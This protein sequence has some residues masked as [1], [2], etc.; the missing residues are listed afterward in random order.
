MHA[1]PQLLLT[2]HDDRPVMKPLFITRFSLSSKSAIGVQTRRFM[3]PFPDA[4]HLYW[5]QRDLR[6]I[7]QRSRSI[8]KLLVSRLSMLRR[9]GVLTR[10][11]RL[12]RMTHWSGSDPSSRIQ[13]RLTASAKDTSV[14]YLAPIG[15][16]DASRMRRIVELI[17]RPF[18]VHLW[19]SLDV[20]PALNADL[21]WLLAHADKVYGLTG[22]LMAASGRDDAEPLLFSRARADVRATPPR[23]GQPL[24]IATMGDLVSYQD[25]LAVL[26]DACARLQARGHAVELLYIGPNGA[27]RRLSKPLREPLVRT[28]FLSSDQRRDEV[29]ASCH[30]GFMPGPLAAPEDDLRSRFSVPSRVLDFMAVGLPVVGT[31]HP[32]SATYAMADD[33]GITAGLRRTA[34]ELVEVVDGLRDPDAWTE[35]AARSRA[36][37][38]RLETMDPVAQLARDLNAL[39]K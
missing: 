8:E 11:G 13:A 22:T 18:V 15:A 31:V 23:P 17:R 28:G 19:D 7:D 25:G 9:P 2:N 1:G 35:A 16:D 38:A 3:M 39:G 14:V 34:A 4:R 36:G 29:L 37:F 30:L 24:R 6:R 12:A 27:W 33:F 10:L 32:R 20:E 26:V 5:E 21:S